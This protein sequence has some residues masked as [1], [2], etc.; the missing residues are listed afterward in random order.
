MEARLL[1]DGFPDRSQS[2]DKLRKEK[3]AEPGATDNPDD[4][5]RI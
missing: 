2:R 5:Q 3:A 1:P 4:A